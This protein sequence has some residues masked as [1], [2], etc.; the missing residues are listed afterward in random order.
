MFDF[1]WSNFRDIHDPLDLA[2]FGQDEKINKANKA[3]QDAY[4]IGKD[5]SDSNRSL[6]KQYLDK[7][8]GTY[9]DMGDKYGDYFSNLEGLEVYDPGQFGDN[10]DKSVDDFYSKAANLRI[11]QA[12]NA[13]TNS[14]ANAGDLFS[15]DYLNELA[16]KQQALATEE[17]DKAYD[18]YNQDRSMA[19]NEFKTNA[20][21]GNQRYSNLYNKN[22]DLLGEASNAR[23]NLTNTYANYY[24]NLA[25]QNN[26]DAQNAANFNQALAAN[27]LS[28]KGLI[29]RILG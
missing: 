15:S 7:V 3:A 11:N 5:A 4:E 18:R 27:E 12:M 17:W 6:Y 22:K 9:G 13:I 28:K 19:L 23:D 8:K 10:Y 21:L 26:T 29:G 2:G 16:A 20:D 1:S 25:N 14:R 24:N